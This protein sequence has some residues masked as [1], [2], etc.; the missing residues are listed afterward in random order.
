M[1]EPQP[2]QQGTRMLG[3]GMTVTV[4][5]SPHQRNWSRVAAAETAG[6]NT[7][8]LFLKQFLGR[9]GTWQPLLLHE[10]VK[11]ATLAA[12]Y[13]RDIVDV[14]QPVHC[15]EDNVTIA[16]SHKNLLSIDELLR[17]DGEISGRDWSE[18]CRVLSD[19]CRAV[20]VGDAESS[21][22]GLQTKRLEAATSGVAL[23][24]KGLEV[25]NLG[26]SAATSGHH[27]LDVTAFDLGKAYI[28]PR[29]EVAAKLLVSIL[30]LNWGRPL[31]RFITGPP[32]RLY[33]DALSSLREHTNMRA[34][35]REAEAQFQQRSAQVQ[36]TNAL[37]RTA[38]KRLIDVIGRRYQAQLLEILE[39]WG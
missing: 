28:A 12:P 1:S 30:L 38:K 2:I 20:V 34:L 15:F 32:E 13:L 16:Y 37:E 7:Q 21:P 25:R 8:Y 9:D 14:L 6:V 39:R 11:S 23:N 27:S 3:A 19:V 17:R 36:A 33:R 5:S 31:R 22:V 10:E 18:I 4:T 35:V 26:V 24:F 29:E